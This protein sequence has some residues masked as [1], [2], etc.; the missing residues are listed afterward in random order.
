MYSDTY[1]ALIKN[2]NYINV[3]VHALI[4]L[5]QFTNF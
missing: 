5:C 4:D 1:C 2:Y 3:C